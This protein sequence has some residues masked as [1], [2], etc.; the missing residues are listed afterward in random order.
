MNESKRASITS[1]I[2]TTLLMSAMLT[3]QPSDLAKHFELRL[4]PAV[5]CWHGDPK[6][7]SMSDHGSRP[8]VPSDL[9]SVR[10]FGAQRVSP[11]GQLIAVEVSGWAL[12]VGNVSRAFGFTNHRTELWIVNRNG[13]EYH[14]ITSARPLGLTQWNPVWS[15]NSQKLAFLSNDGQENVFLETWDRASGRVRRLS[16]SSVDL[17]GSI[18]KT[19]PRWDTSQMLWLDNAR[20]LA[21]MLTDGS[22]LDVFDYLSRDITTQRD[23][24]RTA[25]QGATPTA[26]VASSPPAA[27]NIDNFPHVEL[28]TFD[29]NSGAER[30]LGAVPGLQTMGNH[31]VIVS[32]RTRSA[33]VV[34]RIPPG[35]LDPKSTFSPRQWERTLLAIVSLRD[36]EDVRWV[37]GL[38]PALVDDGG[39]AMRWRSEE[40]LAIVGQSGVG[41]PLYI[42][43]VAEPTAKWQ[44]LAELNGDLQG[45]EDGV[46]I[47][48]DEKLGIS[49][50]D[51]LKDGRIAM[52]VNH[53]DL[54][55]EDL[56]TTWWVLS[57]AGFTRLSSGDLDVLKDRDLQEASKA[58]HLETSDTGRLRE[59]DVHGHETTLLPDLNPQLAEIAVPQLVNFEYKSASGDTLHA[60]LLLPHGYIKG[61]RYPTVVWVYA[62]NTYSADEKPPR[63]DGD[64]F[65]ELTLLTGHGYAVLRPSMPITP[66][67]IPGDPMLHLNEG[68]DPAVDKAVDLGIVD[69]DRLA[70]GGGSYGGYSVFG[71]LTAT[72][73]YRT[74]IAL[75]GVS[76]LATIYG[77]MDSFDRHIDPELA[78]LN[79]PHW[80]EESQLRMGVPPWVDPDRYVRNSP[81]FAADKIDT[82]LLIVAGDLDFVSQ[83]SEMMFTALNRQ[84]KRAEFVRYL[85]EEHALQSPANILD[86]WNRIFAWLDAYLEDEDG[87]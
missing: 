69:P 31:Y 42:A 50:L 17:N 29:V 53:E 24:I 30:A 16:K 75:M 74:A 18:S 68:V 51:W 71:L 63:R 9:F 57:G 54:T 79:G 61:R 8:M 85:G 86:M 73:R 19:T 35:A 67:G 6:D 84:A 82:P 34:I 26:I 14:K 3:G 40:S 25:M 38:E 76:D 72:H 87:R 28:R 27:V 49:K 83:Q 58:V 32:P 20:L 11:D 77:E 13:G 7:M 47:F 10:T 66:T 12:G 5:C 81:F 52:E 23:G 60:N 59:S 33:A 44:R 46:E 22:R 78:A 36:R 1:I 21:L 41:K 65:M 15:P 56:R 45:S 37:N 70:L 62:G 4:S 39:P 43:T 80:T 2:G 64:S 55:R 48:H